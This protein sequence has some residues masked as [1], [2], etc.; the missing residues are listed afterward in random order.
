[1]SESDN[2]I[3]LRDRILSGCVVPFLGAG[4]SYGAHH[5]SRCWTSDPDRMQNQ[6]RERLN[7]ILPECGCDP[8]APYQTLR[9]ILD[10]NKNSLSRLAE[11]GALLIGEREVCETLEIDEY[12]ELEPLASHRYLAYLAREG[13]IREVITTNYDCCIERAFKE[14]LPSG[15]DHGQYLASISSLE[16]YRSEAS[17]H[18]NPG[19]LL[20]YKINGCA[21]IYKDKKA[22]GC[23]QLWDDASRRIIL[24]ERQLQGFR[25]E[26]WARDLLRDRARTQSFL[27]SG[28]GSE[29][30][31]IRHSVLTLL[32]EFSKEYKWCNIDE[33]KDLP[34][35]PFLHSYESTLS[36]Y[37]LQILTGF[38]DVDSAPVRME[39]KPDLRVEPMFANV[40]SGKQ[41]SPLKSSE[42]MRKLFSFVFCELVRTHSVE[43]NTLAIWLKNYTKKYGRWL[44]EFCDTYGEESQLTKRMQ[45]VLERF[46]NP[47]NTKGGESKFPLPLWRL[48]HE[49][50]YP[51]SEPPVD[52]Y[53]PLREDAL[54][55]LVTLLFLARFDRKTWDQSSFDFF[56]TP[57]QNENHTLRVRFIHEDAVDSVYEGN[58]GAWK[59]RLMRL[60]VIPSR[61]SG[62]MNGRWQIERDCSIYGGQDQRIRIRRLW[63]GSWMLVSAGDLV[64]KAGQPDRLLDVLSECFAEIRD[65]SA[66]RLRKLNQSGDPA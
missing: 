34:N 35:S 44:A 58:I 4:F 64:A 22:S 13:V 49:M 52:Y 54:A 18:T 60:I 26:N 23:H 25:A 31:Q 48:M 63:I 21:K 65:R 14:S 62:Y 47:R 16:N 57:A 10:N 53:I 32:D 46:L 2:W 20:V 5:P 9:E 28:F 30:P 36:F 27:F 37:Q 15:T 39:S 3:R 7:S 24:T 11:L 56:L 50:R 1:M 12:A 43:E 40:F 51:G 17:K 41:D 61:L 59:G 55:I 29:E 6:L 19:H 45:D 8:K 42:F 38:F 66:A 33:V